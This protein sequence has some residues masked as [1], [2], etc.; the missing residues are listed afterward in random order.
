MNMR[1]TVTLAYISLI[2]AFMG[3]ATANN[4]QYLLL[5]LPYLT[6]GFVNIFS[7]HNMAIGALGY[8]LKKELPCSSKSMH[9][10]ASEIL[11]NYQRKFIWHRS[12]SAA[13]IFLAP[14]LIALALLWYWG[15]LNTESQY[16]ST[17]RFM[18]WVIGLLTVFVSGYFLWNIHH[19][20]LL[21]AKGELK[22]YF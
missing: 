14:P 22:R 6:F 5:L 7:H 10:D 16:F 3:Y 9:W 8:F 15:F 12:V 20:R 18:F 1:D 11:E 17:I 21:A 19:F 2:V 4:K 13:V